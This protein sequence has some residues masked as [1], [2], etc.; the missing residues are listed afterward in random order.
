M[1]LLNDNQRKRVTVIEQFRI[2]QVNQISL[3]LF[4]NA[5]DDSATTLEIA[6]NKV[7]QRVT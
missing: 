5:T 7:M 3:P 1:K 2:W 4:I 6:T